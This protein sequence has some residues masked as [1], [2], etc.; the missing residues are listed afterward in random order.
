[1]SRACASKISRIALADE[2]DDRLEVELRGE[3]LAD[4]VDERQLGGALVG[5]GQQTLRLVEQAGV[6]EG[7]AHARRERRQAAARR[8]RRRRRARCSR[9]RSTPITRSA[10]HD[11]HA[12]PRLGDLAPTKRRAELRGASAASRGGA[13]GAVCDRRR[14]E[15]GPERHYGSDRRGASP[16]SI[17]RYGTT[18]MSRAC[19]VR[20]RWQIE[21]ASKIARTRSPTSSTIASNSS[22]A[23]RASADLVDER[24]LGVALIGLGQQPLRLVEEARVLERHAHARGERAE[25]PLVGIVEGV[26]ASGSRGRSRR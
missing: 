24:Q 15:A 17:D 3:R 13:A 11:R 22:C 8:P 2:L 23:A 10:G 18:S 9:G 25:E 14:R 1:M 4:L 5:L 26:R 7:D 19:V 12:E 21:S 16:P 6:L 20:A